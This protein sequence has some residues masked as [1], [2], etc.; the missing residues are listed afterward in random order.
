M[1]KGKNI[2]KYKRRKKRKQTKNVSKT[3]QKRKTLHKTLGPGEWRGM[4]M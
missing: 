2:I 1:S 4:K 3:K